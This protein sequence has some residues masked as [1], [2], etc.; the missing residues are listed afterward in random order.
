MQY[1]NDAYSYMAMLNYPYPTSFL[2]N[3]T[4]W[5]ANSSCIPLDTVTPSSSDK[6]LFTAIR[7]S[8]E[9]YYSFEEHKCNE[10]YE[11]QTADEDMSGWNI[12]A[13]GDQAM[14][15]DMDGTND[16]FYPEKFDY[17]AYS[18]WCK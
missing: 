1:V 5:P 14:P 17:Q 12:L 4:A 18:S 6:Q 15:M 2:K 3:L 8:V 16:M 9:Y 11:D 13:C 10:I 7:K